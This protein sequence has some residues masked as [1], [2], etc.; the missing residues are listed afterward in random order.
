VS[1]GVALALQPEPPPD[2]DV[3]VTLP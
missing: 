2:G 3:V 1:A